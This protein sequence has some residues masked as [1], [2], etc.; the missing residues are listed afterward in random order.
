MAVSSATQ[1]AAKRK[2][3]NMLF[4]KK[5]ARVHSSSPTTITTTATMTTTTTTTTTM[6]MAAI[7]AV[8]P[9]SIGANGAA[10]TLVAMRMAK[11]RQIK[12]TVDKIVDEGNVDDQATMICAVIDHPALV[13]ARALAG[14]LGM[15]WHVD[16]YE[17]PRY[18]A[19]HWCVL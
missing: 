4:Y 11:M 19:N 16:M 17:Q 1:A 15:P 2:V 9:W 7:A 10:C 12:P 18:A 3:C 14:I 6:T 13:A 8:A 5:M